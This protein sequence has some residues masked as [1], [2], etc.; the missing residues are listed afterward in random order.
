MKLPKKIPFAAK[1]KA[2]FGFSEL[3]KDFWN[4]LEE[5]LLL[6]DVGVETTEKII[7][8]LRGLKRS[9]EVKEKLRAKLCK[10]IR[11]SGLKIGTRP[12]VIMMVG[13]NGTG[14]TTT[15]AKLA[16]KF[17]GSGKSVI[18]VAADTFRAAAIEQ[19]RVWGNR[20]QIPVFAQDQDSDPAAVVFDGIKLAEARK[21]DVVIIDTAGRLHTN[22][23]LMQELMKIKRV[24]EKA[25]NGSPH[26]VLLVLDATVGQNGL[27]QAKIFNDSLGLTGV[28]L[29]K[30]DGTA[31]GGII[32]SIAD[33]LGL[34]LSFIGVGESI[35]D[36]EEFSPQKFVDEI[37][38]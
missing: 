4:E 3:G 2:L 11:G 7:G 30:M 22:K 10:M 34:P 17:K 16:N 36:L 14:K 38:Q 8:P 27:A 35:D 24:S 12:H 20:L 25:L 15:I 29:A 31:K 6:S 28:V 32:L 18:L 33:E 1:F 19:L 9:D 26:D 23:N 5:L 37:L 21:I 13:V